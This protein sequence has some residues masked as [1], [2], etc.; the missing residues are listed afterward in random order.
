MRDGGI[1]GRIPY[2]NS[3]RYRREENRG[4]IGKGIRDRGILYT[5]RDEGRDNR[6]IEINDR[7]P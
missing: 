5:D 3:G 7:D 4:I 2:D 1:M 6:E